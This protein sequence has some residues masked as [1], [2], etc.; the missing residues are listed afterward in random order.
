MLLSRVEGVRSRDP[1]LLLRRIEEYERRVMEEALGRHP[2]KGRLPRPSDIL[3]RSNDY[4]CLTAD[5]RVINAEINALRALGH[6][7]ISARIWSQ[8]RDD[9]LR[10]FEQELA[11]HMG[12]EDAVI[13]TSG[14]TANI[15][16]IQSIASS[17]TPLYL[18]MKAHKSF[19]E[20]AKSAGCD[21]IAFRH[22]SADHLARLIRHNKP[23]ILVVD[24]LY[25]TNGALC[26]LSDFAQLA[27]ET[28]CVLVV[29]ETHSFGTIGPTGAG[30]THTLGLSDRV[31]FR[32]VGLSK[33]VSSRGGAVVCSR[34]AAEYFRN[35]ALPHIF[36][37]SV[38]PYE[39]VGYSA[40]LAIIA[41]EDWRRRALH[42]NHAH[43]VTGLDQLGY[44]V[45][46]SDAQII[47]L[48]AGD[49]QQAISL[50]D[51]LEARGIFGAI[52]FPPATTQNRCLMRLSLNSRLS[53]EQLE[54]VINACRDVRD[55]VGMAAWRS[56]LRRKGRNNQAAATWSLVA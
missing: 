6:G 55:E 1:E 17:D 9:P 44:N 27:D 32:T 47:A 29:D 24:A 38:L 39:A 42:A 48:E 5:P 49:L 40:I 36:S 8:D 28:D 16:L 19:W 41:G 52:F 31:H 37:T 25:S 13:C 35:S 53:A 43:L 26:P 11:T 4:L 33:A 51:A 21:V 15:G 46:T 14:Y 34:R 22:N 2:L 45:D 12:A 7:D 3:L 50:R 10:Q 56:T 54:R 30:L 23:G 18:D 20:G